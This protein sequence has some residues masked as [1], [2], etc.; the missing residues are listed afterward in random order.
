MVG[1]ELEGR[2]LRGYLVGRRRDDPMPRRVLPCGN[3]RPD[4]PRLG[5]LERGQVHGRSG[6]DQ[7]TEVRETTFGRGERQQVDNERELQI[8]AI[9]ATRSTASFEEQEP[10]ASPNLATL[11]YRQHSFL[12]IVPVPIFPS[13]GEFVIVEIFTQ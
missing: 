4:R 11:M 6:V 13:F 9:L 1:Q 3:R 5:G 12:F 2:Q 8:L 7:A 10:A